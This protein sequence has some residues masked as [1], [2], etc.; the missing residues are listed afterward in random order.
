MEEK[1]E[2]R[3]LTE[4]F[5]A[6]V[7]T[8][9]VSYVI[10]L[11]SLPYLSRVLGV[12]K[13]GLVFWA[14]AMVQYF[15]IFTEFGFSTSAVRDISINRDNKEKISQIF[16]SIMAIKFVFICICFVILSILVVFI[17]KFHHEWL[18][19]YLTFFMV[20]GNAIYP[21][22]FFQGIEHMKY[23][24]FLNI[25]AKGLFLFLIFIFVKQ[26]NDYILVAILNSM[27]FMIAGIIGICLAYK[28][29]GL[30]IVKPKI[31]EIKYQIK[32]SSE[33]FL[34]RVAVAG[35]T[36]TNAFVIGLICN[37]IMVAY[38]T[39]AEKIFQAMNGLSAPI[40]QVLYPFMAK[41]RDINKFKKIFYPSLLFLAG[42][43][44][45]MFIFAKPV[46]SIFY[47]TEMI[48]AY[49]VLR[50][51]C[52]TILCSFITCLIG[53]PLLAAMGHSKEA[54]FSVVYASLVH[55]SGL[56]ILLM[57]GKINIYT[58]A[59]MTVVAEFVSVSYRI[60][61]IKK[62]N[63]WKENYQLKNIKKEI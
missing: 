11:I 7:L 59:S 9:V 42:M 4:N 18:L 33:F 5:I 24:T 50:I 31:D 45:F 34:S 39:A 19:F 56:L 23:I 28:R 22:W 12:E 26:P 1:T 63:L 20:I 60:Y 21:I 62:Y 61:G 43:C 36:N 53:Y 17:P 15:M 16:S 48:T 32:Y 41:Q 2:N 25:T 35:Y 29:F 57:L 3:V 47:G 13:F 6:L 40:G 37:P 14:Q 8:Q 51:F 52:F 30:R 58:V 27:G 10:P 46:V 44:I 49:K 38:Y 54:N 55:I